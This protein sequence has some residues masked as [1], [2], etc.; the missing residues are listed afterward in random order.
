MAETAV[1]RRIGIAGAGPAGLAAALALA[2]DGHAVHLYERHPGLAP[3]GA[4]LLIQPQGLEALAALGLGAE[5]DAVSVP[6]T[7]LLGHTHRGWS[8]VDLDLAKRPARGVSRAQLAGVLYRAAAAAGAVFH[9]G[10][11]VVDLEEAAAG[12][13]VFVIAN[14]AASTL[15]EPAGMAAP[16]VPYAWAALWGQFTVP[17]WPHAEVLLQRYRGTRQMVGLLPTEMTPQGLRLSLFWSLRRDAYEDW[18]AGDLE[19]WKQSVLDLWPEAE[20]AVGQ[21]RRHDDLAL[22]VYRHSWPRRMANPPFAVMGDA[23]HAMSPQLGLGTTLALQD[24]LGLAHALRTHAAVPEALRAYDKD[25]L[26]PARAY[27]TLSRL[28]TPCFQGTHG[29]LV[30]DLAFAWGRKVP[31]VQWAMQRSLAEPPPGRN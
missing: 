25:R 1:R 16:A 27:Q 5:F 8:L 31:G 17:A 15:R 20:G 14:G 13:D 12:H 18:R 11:E 30:R 21:I 10:R 2:R 22:A 6:V 26:L 19:A 4:G 28:L 23:A 3:V 7:R 29:G 9:F 24:A